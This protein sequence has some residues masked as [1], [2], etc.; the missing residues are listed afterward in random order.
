MNQNTDTMLGRQHSCFFPMKKSQW[1]DKDT[2]YQ[3]LLVEPINGEDTDN[4]RQI[5]KRTLITKTR[6]EFEEFLLDDKTVQNLENYPK[7]PPTQTD[8]TPELNIS[9]CLPSPGVV[10]ADKLTET[11][12]DESSDKNII[13]IDNFYDS[14]RTLL[15]CR[16][17]SQLIAK[18]WFAN[19]LSTTKADEEKR[20]WDLFKEGDWDKLQEKADSAVVG[21]ED[22]RL[23][24][25]LD[26][27]IVREIFLYTTKSPPDK[28]EFS[29]GIQWAELFQPDGTGGIPQ[30]A[31]FIILPSSKAW[32]GIT[33]S[34][35]VAGQ[36]YRKVGDKYHQ[37]VQPILSTGEIVGKYHLQISFDISHGQIKEIPLAYNSPSNVFQVTIPYPQV[38]DDLNRSMDNIKEWAYA[39]DE[40]GP[41]P[42]Y[43]K[44][45]EEFLIAAKHVAPPY[46]YIPVSS[47]C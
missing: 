10:F 28:F 47:T 9:S 41:L 22:E 34:L 3:I 6:E 14:M 7:A 37:I 30:R 27:L 1:Y 11:I 21:G 46:P 25:I 5:L 16:K 39:S 38:P 19:S 20:Y 40:D 15:H 36:A 8:T 12:F 24:D 17:T 18:T 45:G 35:L 33:L 4:P 2:L 31:K 43:V 29:E 44:E 13:N 26:N 42:F 23:S 32:Q